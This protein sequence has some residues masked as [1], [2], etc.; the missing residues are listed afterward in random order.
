MRKLIGI[1]VILAGFATLASAQIPTAGNIF[2]GYSY[3][4]TDVAARRSG[5]NG[6]DGSLEGK[7]FPFVGIVADISANYGSLNFTPPGVACPTSGCP[8]NIS[9]HVDN[10]L[11]G[12]RAS[13]S[14]GKI[15][16]FAEALFGVGHASTNGLGSDTSFASG[17][18]GGLDYRVF[19]IIGWR[20]EG[21]YIHTSLF[22]QAQG[23]AR[24]STGV[25]IHF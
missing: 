14:V 19:H 25:V 22:H 23:N 1:I 20:F 21:D 18:G 8:S 2:A 17:L 9:T 5:L 24:F 3:Y 4:S 11:F 13:F 10:V 7:I 12:P 16:L 6:W 15:R